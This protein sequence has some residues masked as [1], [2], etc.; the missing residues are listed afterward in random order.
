MYDISLFW[1]KS[2]LKIRGQESSISSLAFV[3]T[4]LPISPQAASLRNIAAND[5]STYKEV[6]GFLFKLSASH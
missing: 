1:K 2:T 3:A 6:P 4:L 5:P